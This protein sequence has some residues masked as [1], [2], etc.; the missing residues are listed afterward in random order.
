LPVPWGRIALL[1]SV[2]PAVQ[3]PQGPN[4]PEIQH[5]IADHPDLNP[6]SIAVHQRSTQASPECVENTDQDGAP[7]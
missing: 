5:F 4:G 2:A 7:S 1:R 6:I 3:G